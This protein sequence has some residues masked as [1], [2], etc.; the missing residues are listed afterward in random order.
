MKQFINISIG[1]C[2]IFFLLISYNSVYS[3]NL[4]KGSID[5]IFKPENNITQFVIW[6]EDENGEYIGTAFITNFMGRRGGGNRTGDSNI[7]SNTGNRLSAMPIW[8]Y[9]RSVVDTT[10]GIENYYPPSASQPSYPDDI[11]AVSGAT[12]N[13]STQTKTLELSDLPYGSY[14][15]YIEVNKSFDF[16][17]YHNYSFYRAQPSVIWKTT[18]N[19]T[20][21][22]DSNLILD[23]SGYGSIDGSNGDISLPDSTITTATDLLTDMGGYKFKVVYSPPEDDIIENIYNQLSNNY[24]YILNQNYPNPF[25]TSTIIFYSIQKSD[26]VIIKI[27]NYQGKEIQ[28]LVNKFHEIGDYNISFNT[29]NISSGIYFYKLLIGN[30]FIDTKKMLLLQ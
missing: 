25:Y 20:D 6:I 8:A 11:D 19:I 21:N 10:Y 30:D 12:P 2:I 22:P 3:Q 4:S 1:S 26:F 9:K 18:I 14:N 24:L 23:Y 16:N 29:E 27:Y 15:C 28:T 17:D 5:F 7:D 13:T